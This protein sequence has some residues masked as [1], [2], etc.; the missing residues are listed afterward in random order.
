MALMNA[1]QLSI[2][3]PGANKDSEL[4]IDLKTAK[5]LEVGELAA[6]RD[7]FAA[8]LNEVAS[9]IKD[10]ADSLKS[11]RNSSAAK[12]LAAR[13]DAGAKDARAA[14]DA[15]D[16]ANLAKIAA[17]NAGPENAGARAVAAGHAY[18]KAVELAGAM[19]KLPASLDDGWSLDDHAQVADLGRGLRA[20]GTRATLDGYLALTDPDAGTPLPKIVRF[21]AAAYPYALEIAR[22]GNKALPQIEG[23]GYQVQAG[24]PTSELFAAIELVNRIDIAREARAPEWLVNA[25][26]AL[27]LLTRVCS[28]YAGEC[29]AFMSSHDFRRMLA[30]GNLISPFR[31]DPR[32]ATR[33]RDMDFRASPPPAS[34]M[35]Y[36]WTK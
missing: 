34:A 18:Q 10:G 1:E 2:L 33:W 19:A 6:K 27:G 3:R 16:E 13:A 30:Q 7:A 8:A 5:K 24:K 35:P 15:I 31:L 32:W 17:D 21:E 26:T 29:E 14:L 25:R 20:M 28:F 4:A 23:P 12:H 22:A 9:A 11:G 36:T